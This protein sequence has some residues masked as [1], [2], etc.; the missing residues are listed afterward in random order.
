MDK[1]IIIRTSRQ[2]GEETEVTL[3]YAINKMCDI[4]EDKEWVT[5]ALLNGEM[6]RNISFCYQ[7]EKTGSQ[8]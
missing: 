5:K 8:D 2:D 6:L 3:E 7:L 4:P 1:N